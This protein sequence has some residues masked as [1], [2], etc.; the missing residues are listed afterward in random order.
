MHYSS[1]NE[2]LNLKD[3]K[4]LGSYSLDRPSSARDYICVA[5]WG[6]RTIFIKNAMPEI[7]EK[8]KDWKDAI[9]R[10]EIQ[11]SQT[12]SLFFYDPELLSRYDILTFLIKLLI[13]RVWEGPAA[14]LECIEIHER[15]CF[16]GNVFWLSTCSTR[17]W[18]I[19]K[20]FNKFGD[21]IR[22]R[23]WFRGFWEKKELR[24]VGAKNHCHQYF[25]FAFQSER[26]E[27][28]LDDQ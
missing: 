16:L 17:S 22:N 28:R 2:S 15:M 5:N 6:W 24:K 7:A 3:C 4:L 14:K 18:W 20:L 19:L 21:I 12:V 26:R 9:M 11:E 23:W 27:N 1:R 13:P 25:Y 8:W 10:K